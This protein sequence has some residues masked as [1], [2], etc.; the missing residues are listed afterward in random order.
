MGINIL[1]GPSCACV[2]AVYLSIFANREVRS[3]RSTR[4][5][6]S[7]GLHFYRLRPNW[8]SLESFSVAAVALVDETR[9]AS[10]RNNSVMFRIAL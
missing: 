3:M 10:A 4:R 7:D 2:A 8:A 5:R 1:N 6:Q 9:S